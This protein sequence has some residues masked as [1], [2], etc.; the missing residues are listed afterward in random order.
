[1]AIRKENF[2]TG[3]VGPVVYRNYRGKQIISSKARS[4]Y[5]IAE[6]TMKNANTFGKAST[7]AC[8]I[9]E[10]LKDVITPNYDGTMPGRL[11]QEIVY[12]LTQARDPETNESYFWSL[13]FHPTQRISV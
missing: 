1:M 13:Q 5:Y 3:A 11:V 12:T 7:F 8:L 4:K 6:G 10:S 2:I 9:R